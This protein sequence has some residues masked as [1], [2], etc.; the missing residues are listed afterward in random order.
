MSRRSMTS[1]RTRG[2]Q[3][4]CSR[5]GC[6]VLPRV[7][8]PCSPRGPSSLPSH[9]PPPRPT[10]WRRSRSARRLARE[11]VV[12]PRRS[13][14]PPADAAAPGPPRVRLRPPPRDALPD[15]PARARAP[16]SPRSGAS[17]TSPAPPRA[18]RPTW[19][20]ATTSRTSRR[21]ARARSRARAAGWRGG[22]G[23]VIAWGCGAQASPRATLNAWLN[24]RAAPRD[25][26]R[27][28]PRRGRRRKKIGG[29]G[30]RA[31]WVMDVG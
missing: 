17:A 24:S 16:A 28:R 15:Q 31:Y 6:G 27:R 26:A 11:P 21:P 3:A 13:R 9:R 23:E 12:R 2:V 30:G 1:T 5:L 10:S 4:C 20:A 25:R 18:T 22:V 19:P 7:L 8:R 14:P 29:C